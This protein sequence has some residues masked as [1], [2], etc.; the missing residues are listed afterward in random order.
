[1]HI[2]ASVDIQR[3]V[4][5]SS[6]ISSARIHHCLLLGRLSVRNVHIFPSCQV[7]HQQTWLECFRGGG[8]FVQ[9]YSVYHMALQFGFLTN[10][11]WP[12]PQL[13][14]DLA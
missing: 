7:P 2:L 11:G 1:M 3:C 13:C 8:V 6:I 12:F 4:K 14:S 10:K 9:K 5:K